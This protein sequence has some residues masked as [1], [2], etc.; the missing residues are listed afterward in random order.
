MKQV[1]LQYNLPV[2]VLREGKKF[3]AF[4]PVLDLS[5]SGDNFE[6][7]NKRFVEIAEIFFEEIISKGTIDE[8]LSDLG[9][10]KTTK[11]W[12]PPVLISQQS[13]SIRVSQ[14]CPA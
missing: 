5:T 10:K 13:E 6:E 2:N 1:T 8:V 9:W 4:S 11:Q 14:I 3:V 7:V 12:Q